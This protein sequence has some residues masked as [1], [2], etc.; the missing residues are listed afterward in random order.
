MATLH[1]VRMADIERISEASRLGDKQPLNQLLTSV[2]KRLP[3]LSDAVSH[4][5]LVHVGAAHQ[6]ANIRRKI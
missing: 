6:I 1:E 4:R 2:A 3:L 5:Y